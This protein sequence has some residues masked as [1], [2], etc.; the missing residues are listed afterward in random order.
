M[1]IYPTIISTSKVIFLCSDIL[2]GI[3]YQNEIKKKMVYFFLSS[4][5]DKRFVVS[6]SVEFSFIYNFN[7]SIENKTH[8]QLKVS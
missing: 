2:N 3:N 5:Q 1:K 7:N 8:H 6:F 4:L